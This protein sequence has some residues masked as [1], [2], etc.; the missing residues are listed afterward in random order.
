MSGVRK[1]TNMVVGTKTNKPLITLDTEQH[2]DRV[3]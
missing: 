1:E 3:E 2:R